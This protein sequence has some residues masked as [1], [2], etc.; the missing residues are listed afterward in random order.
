MVLIAAWLLPGCRSV[1]GSAAPGSFAAPQESR[2]LGGA[3]GAQSPQVITLEVS[4]RIERAAAAA[5]GHHEAENLGFR[6]HVELRWGH[7][8]RLTAVPVGQVSSLLSAPPESPP[9]PAAQNQARGPA[10]RGGAEEGQRRGMLDLEV[11]SGGFGPES[12]VL[13]FK[14]YAVDE[15]TGKRT[16]V[17]SPKMIAPYG[18]VTEIQELH[19]AAA[20]PLSRL[21]LSVL[22][23]RPTSA[24]KATPDVAPGQPEPRDGVGP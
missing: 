6:E 8:L 13:D 24:P 11:T 5:Q 3:Q 4:G 12:V 18:T 17:A 9:Q 2:S 1:G 14:L 23:S 10:R 22:P 7:T 20:A 19:T 16:L 21:S 15:Q